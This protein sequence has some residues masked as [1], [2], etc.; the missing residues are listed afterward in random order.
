[1]PVGTTFPKTDVET[2][3]KAGALEEELEVLFSEAPSENVSSAVRS[4]DG[5]ATSLG[6]LANR[7]FHARQRRRIN[8]GL[9]HAPIIFAEHSGPA[10]PAVE[11]GRKSAAVVWAGTMA[12][13]LTGPGLWWLLAGPPDPADTDASRPGAPGETGAGAESVRAD[14]SPAESDRP[15]PEGGKNASAGASPEQSGRW[16]ILLSYPGKGSAIAEQHRL[17]RTGVGGV[18]IREVE[19]DGETWYQLEIMSADEDVGAEATAAPGGGV[20]ATGDG[21]TPSLPRRQS[22][23][24]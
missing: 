9:K 14:A 19:R 12:L 15:A 10:E 3:S 6:E 16:S 13:A 20:P 23:D 17:A 24:D 18:V 4:T 5:Q 11:S 21:R 22:G 2:V 8:A 1:M 7:A